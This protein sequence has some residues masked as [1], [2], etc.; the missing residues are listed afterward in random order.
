[1]TGNKFRHNLL[2]VRQ[3]GTIIIYNR[4][5]FGDNTQINPVYQL[6]LKIPNQKKL[7]RVSTR[8][9]DKNEAIRFALEKFDELYRASLLGQ[10]IHST[11]F[12]KALK[13]FES[14]Y[15]S[16]NIQKPSLKNRQH[17]LAQLKN[18]PYQFFVEQ[19]GDIG[20]EKI[21]PEVIQRYYQY[22]Q[23]QHGVSNNT[24]RRETTYIN[25]FLSWCLQERLITERPETP[26]PEHQNQVRATFTLKEWR[27]IAASMKGWVEC[28]PNDAIH[29]D[30]FY[31]RD[32]VLLTSNCGARPGEMRVL[33]WGQ[34][35]SHK[36]PNGEVRMVATF[37][38]GK[39][40]KR[41]TVFN[42]GSE[43]YF[44]RLWDYRKE[45]LGHDPS[46]EECVFCGS[47]GREVSDRKKSFASLLNYCGLRTNTAG[48]VRSLYSLRHFYAHQ[49]L[50]NDPPTSVYDLAR[51]MGTSVKVIESNYGDRDNVSRGQN[52]GRKSGSWATNRSD[53]KNSYPFM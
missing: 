40:G 50:R 47:D 11:P 48:E 41:E 8:T 1:M 43:T 7:V 52:I 20:V 38:T 46:P 36:Y 19:Q 26:R 13:G 51:N 37:P 23:V 25:A 53:S 39:T 29:R 10:S 5:K 18:H 17:Y 14:Y 32:L 4:P 22:R 6:E 44:K 42:T 35:N 2:D 34:V 24:L 16:P 15:L 31:L 3:D 28:A 49:Q 9:K 45:E 21:T 33:K 30:R 12:T 27:S